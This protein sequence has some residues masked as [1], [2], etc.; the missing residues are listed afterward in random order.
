MRRLNSLCMLIFV[1]TL[2]TAC[3]REKVKQEENPQFTILPVP[4]NMQLTEGNF[5]LSADTKIVA[6]D[7]SEDLRSMTAYLSAEL[8]KLVQLKTKVTEAASTD[9][10]NTIFL[11]ID[12]TVQ[13]TVKAAS[14]VLQKDAYTLAVQPGKV[15]IRGQSAAALFYGV[16]TFLQLVYPHEQASVITIPAMEVQDYPQ[17]SWRGMHF[18]VCRHFFSVTFIKKMIDAMA[19]HKL[20]TFHWHLTD[21]QGWR[22]EI[23]K[24]PKLTDVGGW[25]KET[26][27]GHMSGHPLKYD[28]KQYG[29]FYTQEQIKEVVAYAKSRYVTVVPEIEMPG[30]AMAALSA[31][32]EYSCTGGPFDVFTEWGETKEVFC[33]GKEKTFSFIEDV[34][35]EVTTLFPGAYIHVGGDEC[36]TQRPAECADCKQRMKKEQLKDALALQSYFIKQIETYLNGKGKKLIGWDE[37]LDGGLPQSATVMSWRGEKGGISASIAGHD[38]VM[39][40]GKYCYFDHCQGNMQTE[41]LSIGGFLPLDSVYAYSPLPK[42]LDAEKLKHI[43]GAQAN[44]WTEYVP[45][46]N[47]FEY[48]VFPRLCAMAEILWSPKE[49][50]NY[51]DF[52]NRMDKQYLR[53]DKKNILYRVSAPTGFNE[54]NKFLKDTTTVSMHNDI[55]SAEIRYTLDGTEPVKSSM[56][57]T[58]PFLLS[59]KEG[60]KKVIAKSFLRNG[61]TSASLTGVFETVGLLPGK[62]LTKQQK[63]VTYDYYDQQFSAAE[64]IKG[65]PTKSGIIDSLNLPGWIPLKKEWFALNYNGYIKI[66]K[67]GLYTFSLNADDGAVLYIDDVLVVDNDGYHYAQEKSGNIGLGEGYHSIR[68]AYFEGKYTPVLEVKIMCQ[69]L[70]KQA[71]PLSMLWHE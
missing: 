21:D 49:K 42:G 17:F 53:L 5:S 20:N 18:D 4:V 38:V 69:G 37:I 19:M 48:M 30:H 70:K 10:S 24:Y 45:S 51:V 39:T 44:V 54:V 36:S 52:T 55:P 34:L 47:Q 41:P 16:Q 33:A 59:L 7:T 66:D 58:E 12:T 15:I 2:L 62:A 28:G 57:Y 13:L 1:L 22:I 50:Q 65:T 61:K 43:L 56:L 8:D 35:D 32:P 63:G 25:R 6:N 71:I 46:E 9:S 68:L 67:E 3:K 26:V 23:K 40:P 27:I 31:Y 64:K 60:R 29:G 14:P 11:V